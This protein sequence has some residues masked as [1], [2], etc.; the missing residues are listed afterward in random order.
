MI[1]ANLLFS[2]LALAPQGAAPFGIVADAPLLP[3]AIPS[4]SPAGPGVSRIGDVCHVR[5]MRENDLF[6]TGV[7]VGLNGTGDSAKATRQALVNLLA[8]QSIDVS[9]QDLKDGAASLV[10]V[11]AKLPAFA[12]EG[13]RIDV[14]I[15]ALGDAESLFGGT[16]LFTPLMGADGGV[17]ATAQGAIT[18]GGFSAAGQASKISQNHPTVATIHGGAVVE[19]ELPAR[20]VEDGAFEL[21]LLDPDFETARRIVESIEAVAPGLASTTD[22]SAVRVRLPE[23]LAERQ[24]VA[25]VATVTQLNVR[26]HSKARVIVNERTGT[27]VA[28]DRVRIGRC[29]IAHGNL[30]V[31]ISESP[32]V[33]QPA[34]FSGGNTTV[35]PRTDVQATVDGNGL[36][37]LPETTTIGELAAALNAL[38]ATPRD[39]VTILQSLSA[40]GALHAELEVR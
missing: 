10:M 5:G 33:S 16:L 40:A 24:Q 23:D 18:I 30:T 36:S 39:M 29:A 15:S 25:F 26:P 28:G 3:L 2:L 14:T 34:P 11:T 1:A 38:G 27:I 32:A 9:L 20:F 22:P 21:R 17:W 4:D 6:G 31:T 13:D 12:R 35:V 19:E 7:V 8:K 37:V